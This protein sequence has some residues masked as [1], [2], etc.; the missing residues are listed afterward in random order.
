VPRPS[1]AVIGGQLIRD[2]ALLAWA[3]EVIDSVIDRA[4]VV[5]PS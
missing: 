4:P 5:A 2:E 1:T 3:R